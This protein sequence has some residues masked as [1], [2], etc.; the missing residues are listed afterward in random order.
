MRADTPLIN[1]SQAT[2]VITV[3][4]YAA[5]LN[6]EAASDPHHLYDLAMGGD[7]SVGNIERSGEDG[8]YSYGFSQAAANAP[9]MYVGTEAGMRF[10][11]WLQNIAA[12]ST[13]TAIVQPCLSTEAGTYDLRAS[14]M[15]A[16]PRASYLLTSEEEINFTTLHCNKVELIVVFNSAAVGQMIGGSE[17]E[18]IGE[19]FGSEEFIETIVTSLGAVALGL[20]TGGRDSE[21]TEHENSDTS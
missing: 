1:F 7:P 19:I 4:Q 13:E 17:V 2:N 6:A 5:F 21:I 8:H 18:E 12:Q 14:S 10:C 15:V 11:N 16:N 3:S 9:I 20:G